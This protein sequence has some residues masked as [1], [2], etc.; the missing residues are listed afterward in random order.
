MSARS[1]TK[2]PRRISRCARRRAG[3]GRRSAT[4]T[5]A[6]VPQMQ[7]AI[8]GRL[9]IFLEAPADLD[10]RSRHVAVLLRH[11]ERRGVA[12]LLELRP[13]AEQRLIRDALT[14]LL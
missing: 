11:E 5:M 13:A 12:D 7:D 10:R 6:E 1:S 14:H 3:R 2:P 8:C 9:D 4:A